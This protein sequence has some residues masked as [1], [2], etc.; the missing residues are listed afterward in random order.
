MLYLG[1]L[2]LDMG[3]YNLYKQMFN[4]V[5]LFSYAEVRAEKRRAFGFEEVSPPEIAPSSVKVIHD[6]PST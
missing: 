5:L 1:V 3:W 6:W 4:Y 2:L